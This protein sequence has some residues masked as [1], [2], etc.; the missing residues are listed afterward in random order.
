MA[1]RNEMKVLA[2]DEKLADFFPRIQ[3]TRTGVKSKVN[4]YIIYKYAA[5]ICINGQTLFNN[6]TQRIKHCFSF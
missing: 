2:N 3:L 5:I 4:I 1:P 6:D